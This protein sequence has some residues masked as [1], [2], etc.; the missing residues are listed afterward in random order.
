M[1][2]AGYVFSGVMGTMT[3]Q[4]AREQGQSVAGALGSAIFDTALS[5]GL[6][7]AGY[8]AYQA[9]VDGPEMIQSGMNALETYKRQTAAAASNKA[10]VNSHFN[11]SDQIFT[12]RQAG[13][14]VAERSKYNMQ[15]AMMGNEA[16][17]MRK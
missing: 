1:A 5:I 2:T 9:I 15:Q 14:A 10:F 13:M 17:Y 7:P 16:R 12:M 11:D 3:Y 8:M 4:D 6:S